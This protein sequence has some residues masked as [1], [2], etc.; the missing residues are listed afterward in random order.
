MRSKYSRFKI[1]LFA[2]VVT[3]ASC[4]KKD[5]F[6]PLTDNPPAIPVTVSN[7]TD[8]RPGPTVNASKAN[9]QVQIVLSIPA[10]SGRTIKEITKVAAAT[11]L[12]TIQGS[13]GLYTSTPIPGSGTTATFNT[14][15]TEYTAKTGQA[16]PAA[17]NE[18]G[19][20]FYFLVTLDDGTQIIP[21][22]V[23]V[24]VTN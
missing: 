5:G 2:L 22:E 4:E 15:F 21:T 10:N 18:L 7:A 12:T 13:T 17:N 1:F 6:G 8:Y 9:G 20:R 24:L 16:I 3:A 23:R 11:S 19:R 14:T